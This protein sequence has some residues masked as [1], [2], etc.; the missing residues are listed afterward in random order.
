S[1]PS[2]ENATDHTA[3]LCPCKVVSGRLASTSQS[4]TVP[5]TLALAAMLP[6]PESA[7]AWIMPECPCRVAR[8]W[9]L[10]GSQ[11]LTMPSSPPL[12]GHSPPLRHE[13]PVV[14]HPRV[15]VGGAQSLPPLPPPAPA[16]TAPPA[17]CD[18]LPAPRDRHCPTPAGMPTHG[19]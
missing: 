2:R 9:P 14:A 17:P 11:N 7:R 8:R 13:P 5:S 15:P 19:Q 1:R 4:L 18:Q 16:L 3:A 6:S 12:A 10:D